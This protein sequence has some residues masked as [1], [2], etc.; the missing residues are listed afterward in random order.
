[1]SAKILAIM[2]C[3]NGLVIQLTCYGLCVMFKLCTDIIQAYTKFDIDFQTLL[4]LDKVQMLANMCK[5]VQATALTC[6]IVLIM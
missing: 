1:M 4:L 2:P 6:W 3:W 5:P